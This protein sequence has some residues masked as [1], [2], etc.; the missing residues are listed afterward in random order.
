[1]R[2]FSKV[3]RVFHFF[4]EAKSTASILLCSVSL[5]EINEGHRIPRTRYFSSKWRARHWWEFS[6]GRSWDQEMEPN[7]FSKEYQDAHDKRA[8]LLRHWDQIQNIANRTIG[9]FENP[10]YC[11][12]HDLRITASNFGLVSGVIRKSSYTLSLFKTLV[13]YS[14][15]PMCGY[16]VSSPT[17][18]WYFFSSGP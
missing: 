15:V 2:K 16:P 18:C 3:L 12:L 8:F 5:Q 6:W 17:Y 9:Q 10:M 4:S 1:M 11:R 7:S 13:G 14:L